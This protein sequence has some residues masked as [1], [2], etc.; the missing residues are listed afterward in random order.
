MRKTPPFGQPAMPEHEVPVEA[1]RH[2]RDAIWNGDVL[3][4]RGTGLTDAL[5]RIGTHSPYTH[6]AI[7]FR[8]GHEPPFA[9]PGSEVDRVWMVEAVGSGVQ[10]R[11]LSHE[12]QEYPGVVEL[13]RLRA[14]LRARLSVHR[15]V[16]VARRCVG[17]GYGYL[18]LVGFV[19]DWLTLG[20]LHLRSRSRSRRELFCSQLVSLAYRRGGVDLCPQYGDAGTAP[21]DLI[22]GSCLE[23]VRVFTH[24]ERVDRAASAALVSSPPWENSVP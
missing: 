10:E 24:D 23:F 20:L 1:Y 2:A 5:V 11:P 15:V 8:S 22:S 19:L 9:V 18:L 13:W 21:G 7:A 3:M 12:L 6:A 14:P 17:H 4:F 16:R